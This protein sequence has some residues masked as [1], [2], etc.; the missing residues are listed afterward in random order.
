MTM[1]IIKSDMPIVKASCSNCI[2]GDYWSDV[3]QQRQVY[4]F[5]CSYPIFGSKLSPKIDTKLI[6]DDEIANS[7]QKYQ[8]ADATN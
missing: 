6:T 2:F 7:C 1:K 5:D 4:G 3:D 8:L